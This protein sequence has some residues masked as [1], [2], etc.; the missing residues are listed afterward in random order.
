M[1]ISENESLLDN[2]VLFCRALRERGL[3]VTPSEAIES[4]VVLDL[5]DLGNRQE[6]FLSLRSV[7]TS[8]REDFPVFEELFEDFWNRLSRT[9]KPR[10]LIERESEHQV[11]LSSTRRGKGLAFFLEHWGNAESRE[12]ESISTPVASSTV[13]M[14]EK[15]FSLFTSEELEEISRLTRRIVRRLARA[16]SRRWEPVRRGQRVNLR[17]TLRRSLTTAGEVIQLSFRRRKPKKTRLVVISDVSGSMDIYSRILL[18]FVYGLQ[19]SFARVE[20]FVFST[21]LERITAHLKQRSYDEALGRLSSVQGWSGGTMIGASLSAFNSLWSNLV[22]KRTIV[23]ILSDGWD[24]GEPSELAAS[25]AHIKDRA[26][27]LIWLN[28][29][30]GS[31]SYQPLVR[32]MQAAIPFIDVFAPLHNLA[33]LRALEQHLVL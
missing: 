5:I 6:T 21:S 32:G 1:T 29:L 33:T 31:P 10:K 4:V 17:R 23:I 27:R 25:L 24:T 30:L 9:P 8:R 28:P 3:L 2:T 26:G 12:A 19:T 22:D 16:P 11:R 14:A 18:Q 7:L 15:D 20:T 13:S